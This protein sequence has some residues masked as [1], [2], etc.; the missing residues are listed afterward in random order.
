MNSLSL[1]GPLYRRN[2]TTQTA[3]NP[4][5]IKSNDLV[6]VER[7][8]GPSLSARSQAG[9]TLSASTAPAQQSQPRRKAWPTEIEVAKY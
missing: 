9:S 6:R 3:N 4:M 7:P 8:D 2:A 1:P 5:K